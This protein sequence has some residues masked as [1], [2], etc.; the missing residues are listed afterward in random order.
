M[1]LSAIYHGGWLEYREALAGGGIRVRVRCA[2]GDWE[3][4]DLLHQGIYEPERFEGKF[5]ETPMALVASDGQHDW[6]QADYQPED[7]RQCYFFRFRKQDTE[8]YFDQD[9]VKT[10]EEIR[11]PLAL[12][13]FPYA[14][15]YEKKPLADWAKGSVGYQIFPDRFRRA[16][17]PAPGIQPW[18]GK[19]IG[20]R[21]FFGGDLKGITESVPYLKELGVE[22]V[23]LTPIFL[24]DTAH[25]YNTFDY[26]KI[27]P[28]LGDLSDLK[29][30]SR[31]LHDAGMKLIL[32][33][34]FNHCGLAFA[35][36]KD[37]VRKGKGSQY[38]DWFFFDEAVKNGYRG[39][40]YLRYMP[41]LNL[42]DPEAQAYFLDVGRYWMREADIDGWRL[43]VSPEVW[44]DFWRQFRK[45]IQQEKPEAIMVAECWDESREWVSVGDMFDAT[46]HYVLSRAIWRFFALKQTSL[47]QFDHAVNRAQMLYPSDLNHAQWTFLSSHDT[48]RFISR[49]EGDETARK[50]ASFFQMTVPG[51]PIIYYGDELGM[52]GGN[53]PDCRRPMTWNK[54]KSNATLD[55]YKRLTGIRRG[56]PALKA[57]DFRTHLVGEDGLYAYIRT[58]DQPVLC[59]IMTGDKAGERR[60]PLPGS[61]RNKNTLH[62]HMQGKDI[63]VKDGQITLSLQRGDCYALTGV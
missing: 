58:G 20:Q 37:A 5:L 56:L 46:M 55:W 60:I 34:V 2:P 14:Y 47:T 8:I 41:K 15:V 24:S 7:P 6:Y 49:A 12:Q 10:G 29:E 62:D 61:M 52:E 13:P 25:R 40:A 51:L 39:F 54:V 21:S 44:P 11:Q 48:C 18:D 42:R 31:A 36:F 57:G 27:D 4:V 50:M 63:S 38:Y 26:Y 32:D 53:D 28:M 35:P 16:A 3:A 19:E 1:N 17:G 43:D 23:Y 9:G 33:G 22:L 45:A 59:L 30:L